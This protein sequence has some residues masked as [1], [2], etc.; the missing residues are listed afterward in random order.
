MS[1]EKNPLPTRFSSFSHIDEKLGL[2]PFERLTQ[3]RDEVRL[4]DELGFDYFFTAEHHFSRTRGLSTSEGVTSAIIAQ[5]SDRMRFGPMT[6]QLPINDPLRVAEEVVILDH[7]SNGRFDV[8]FSKG[9]VPHELITYGV[10]PD[11]AQARFDEALEF[12]LKAWTLDERFS[13]LGH[14]NSYFDVEMT[15]LPLQRPYPPIWIPTATPANAEEWGK[16]G[17]KTA[18]FAFLGTEAHKEVFSRYKDGYE[19]S[20]APIEDRRIGYLMAVVVAGTDAEAEAR[21]VK[22]F[23]EYVDIF[24]YETE[25]SHAALDTKGKRFTAGLFGLFESLRDPKVFTEDFIVVH[26]SPSTVV[27]KMKALQ[28]LLDIDTLIT[29]FNIGNMPWEHVQESMELFAA[30][31]MPHFER[32][33]QS[34]LPVG[35]A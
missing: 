11:E 12:M 23:G 16:R 22:H 9:V 3:F 8:G 10:H 30:D 17:Y 26:G 24:V 4:A 18:G 27:A 2:T 6:Y 35:A 14:H 33:A 1:T 13:S 31:V 7:M 28:E 21:S 32:A 19:E 15:Q 20:G 5:N 34:E 25:R 29:E